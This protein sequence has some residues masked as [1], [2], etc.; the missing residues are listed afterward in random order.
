ERECAEYQLT[1][2][3]ELIEH[4]RALLRVECAGGKP[5]LRPT[6]RI[7][8]R[9]RFGCGIT[10]ARL[11]LVQQLV[12]AVGLATVQR[13]QLRLQIRIHERIEPLPRL[14][15]MTVG[16][17]DRAARSVVHG[18]V[19]RWSMQIRI[20]RFRA[21]CNLRCG[22]LTVMLCALVACARSVSTGSD[23]AKNEGHHDE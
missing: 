20:M 15:H 19:R 17:V 12:N 7:F 10:F 4:S 9:L 5:T 13:A 18:K 8:E 21:I 3:P 16:V 11:R 2:K 6:D 22:M 1:R 14:H 23:S